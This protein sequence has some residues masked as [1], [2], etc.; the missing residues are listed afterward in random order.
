MAYTVLE[1]ND[2]TNCVSD[3]DAT[4]GDEVDLTGPPAGITV[5]GTNISGSLHNPD[6]SYTGEEGTATI[7]IYEYSKLGVDPDS[8]SVSTMPCNEDMDVHFAKTV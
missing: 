2:C 1:T 3:N 4:A 7:C 6:T 5:S 8:T